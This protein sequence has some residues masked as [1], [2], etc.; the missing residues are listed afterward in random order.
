MFTGLSLGDTWNSYL[1]KSLFGA[2]R[3]NEYRTNWPIVLAAL[4]QLWETGK[5][6]EL[7]SPYHEPVERP[8]V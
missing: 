1:V 2:I 5:V 8:K 6:S 7:R 4:R 3:M